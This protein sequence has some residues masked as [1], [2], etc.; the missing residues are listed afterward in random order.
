VPTLL[1][2][3]GL[4]LGNK[5]SGISIDWNAIP[6]AMIIIIGLCIVLSFSVL[7]LAGADRALF[8]FSPRD[9]EALNNRSKRAYR[10]FQKYL[11]QPR[12]L[13][14]SIQLA[15]TLLSAALVI[16]L[17]YISLQVTASSTSLW[18]PFVPE[19]FLVALWMVLLVNVIPNA[20]AEKFNVGWT[21]LLLPG[22]SLFY[23][24][25]KPFAKLMIYSEK[26][27]DD[28]VTNLTESDLEEM[29]QEAEQNKDAQQEQEVQLLKGVMKFGSIQVKQVMRPRPDVVALNEALGFDD[30]VKT[31]RESG[32]SRI[33]VYKQSL[34]N[35]VGVLYTKDLLAFLQNGSDKNWN[36]LIREAFFV[37]EGKKIAELLIE[38][39]KKMI[40]LAIVI[41]EYGSTAGIVT[42]EDILEEIIGEI[43][44]E[45]DDKSEMEFTK[46]D[47]H[48]YIFE[49]KTLLNDVYKVMGIKNFPFDDVKGDVESVGGL[50]MELSGKMP[51][52]KEQLAYKN[53]RFEI[54]AVE[55]HRVKKVK[56]SHLSEEV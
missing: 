40:H 9:L 43:H 27:V 42:L 6:L 38:F 29:N 36:K 39:Q 51:E 10:I 49:G 18:W 20:L 15:H 24:F 14:A 31:V 52:E 32:Y 22:L 30:V 2:N 44:D 34:D 45:L 13:T 5:S 25:I 4:G 16:L 41:D 47:E 48:T 21:L 1:L 12:L 37:P 53:Y 56:V 26:K 17:T 46:L 8:S 3:A 7:I 19:I 35:V 54:L 50:V 55:Q 28:A 11:E 23:F 33:P